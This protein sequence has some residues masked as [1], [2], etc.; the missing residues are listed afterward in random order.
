MRLWLHK[1]EGLLGEYSPLMSGSTERAL[2]KAI[3]YG[4]VFSEVGPPISELASR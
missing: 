3:K 4:V 1:L 2:E